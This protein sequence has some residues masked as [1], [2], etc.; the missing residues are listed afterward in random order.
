ME[1]N[2][3]KTED[4]APLIIDNTIFGRIGI[5]KYNLNGETV[6]VLRPESEVEKSVDSFIGVPV[7]LEHPDQK[8]VNDSNRDDVT[9]GTTPKSFYSNGFHRGTLKITDAIAQEKAKTTHQQISNGYR[10]KLK[11]ESGEWVDELGV[12]GHVGAKYKYDYIQTDIEGNHIALVNRGRAGAIASLHIDSVDQT[13]NDELK[14]ICDAVETFN[15]VN[16]S[17]E[18]ILT[19]NQTNQDEEIVNPLQTNDS[20]SKQSIN[21]NMAKQIIFNDEVIDISEENSQQIVDTV[22][23][24][25]NELKTATDSLANKENEVSNLI[26]EKEKAV[27][28]KDTLQQELDKVQNDKAS[29]E[30]QL[31]EVKQQTSDEQAIVD[32]IQSRL[33]LWDEVKD[34]IDMYYSM[35]EKEIKKAFLKALY[36]DMNLEDMSK[37]YLDACYD[38]ALRHNVENDSSEKQP[39]E[40][41]RETVSDAMHKHSNKKAKDMNKTVKRD[42][43]LPGTLED[44]N[45]RM[46]ETSQARHY[47]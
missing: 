35:K 36:P 47:K 2:K 7:T 15:L 43:P 6:N 20:D 46:G 1:S 38:M 39:D 23:N 29:L 28:E 45:R 11:K 9:K 24:L 41:N 27:G 18:E 21:K 8:E 42:M 25:K 31:E 16:D 22:N 34:V 40:E 5:Q 14:I 19:V 17:T 32:G 13:N 4:I 26:S 33:K 30:T 44:V 12:H 3:E 10:T 37:E